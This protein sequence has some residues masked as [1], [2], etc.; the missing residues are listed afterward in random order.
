MKSKVG[1]RDIALTSDGRYTFVAEWLNGLVIIDVQ[2]PTAPSFAGRYR[3]ELHRKTVVP[4][5]LWRCGRGNHRG[6][7]F[8]AMQGFRPGEA[9]AVQFFMIIIP[10]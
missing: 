7:I 5:G 4:I 10:L 6:L 9:R 1:A 2:E 3:S 8:S